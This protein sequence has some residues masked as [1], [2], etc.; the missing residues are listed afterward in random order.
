MLAEKLHYTQMAITKAVED[1]KQF[2]LN[3]KTKFNAEHLVAMDEVGRGAMA[4]IFA[5]ACV[6]LPD[7]YYNPKITDSKKLTSSQREEFEQEIKEN[8]LYYNI[9]EYS[10]LEIDEYGI[11]QLNISL[12][13][14]LK[15][16]VEYQ[17]TL[18]IVDGTI[19]ESYQ[20]FIMFLQENL[21]PLWVRMNCCN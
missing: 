19:M 18:C 2:D 15:E 21:I 3:L 11:Q 9:I 16:C 5:G 17:N 14:K 8:A 10:N 4:F 12:F 20:D 1:L 13:L 6:I 7:N